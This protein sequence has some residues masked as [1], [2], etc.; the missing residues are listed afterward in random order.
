MKSLPFLTADLPGC[1]GAFKLTPE[2]FRVD[3]VPA[4]LPQGDGEHLFLHVEKRGRSTPDVGR[5][6]ARALEAQERDVSWAGLKDRQA[7]TTQ[8]FCVF[9][10]KNP[11]PADFSINGV[12]VLSVSRHRNK[13]KTGHLKGNRFSLRV[14]G[15]SDFG[16]AEAVVQQLQR[17]GVPNYFGT[18]RFG[19]Q[20]DNADRGKAILLSGGRHRDRFERKLFLSAFQSALFNEVLAQRVTDGLFSAVLTGDV[21]KKHETNGEFICADAAVDQPRADSF[22]VSATGPMFGPEMRAPEG[23][24]SQ[25]EAAVLHDAQVTLETFKAGGDETRGTRRFLRMVPEALTLTREADDAVL[26]FSLPPGSYA[27]C[28]LREL[29]K[30]DDAGPEVP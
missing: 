25:R 1:G 18:Q 17:L 4:Y 3:E 2:D 27:T 28:V 20:G 21:L 16:I 10:K 12:T 6:L 24:V 22:E 19:V 14:R 29:L 11:T 15:V 23:Q 9:T 30:R 13:L 8:W 7:V 5:Q 26:A